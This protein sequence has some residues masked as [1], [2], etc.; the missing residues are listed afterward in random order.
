MPGC[1]TPDDRVATYGKANGAIRL[2]LCHTCKQSPMGAL[3]VPINETDKSI[4]K[5]NEDKS[6]ERRKKIDAALEASQTVALCQY[7]DCKVEDC[8]LYVTKAPHPRTGQFRG[9]Y[10][11]VHAAVLNSDNRV[12]PYRL[13]KLT[14]DIGHLLM[15]MRPV[16]IQK[17]GEAH[18]IQLDMVRS[19]VNNLVSVLRINV[20]VDGNL[21]TVL[22]TPSGGTL[23]T[24]PSV[25]P[26]QQE[27]TS[28]S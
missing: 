20:R 17:L 28:A 14:E 16:S 8:K 21:V 23:N 26:P 3:L 24:T 10:C 12:M 4:K 13:G 11:E 2:N 5:G 7:P 19:I 25:E 6:D 1:K 15:T 9:R 18:G 27:V 22:R